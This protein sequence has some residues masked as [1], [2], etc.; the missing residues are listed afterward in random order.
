MK[1]S[2]KPR[3]FFEVRKG[4]KREKHFFSTNRI[5]S[6]NSI[7]ASEETLPFS[8]EYF[9]ADNVLVLYINPAN[10]MS[11][12]QAK[13]I[14]DF[15]SADDRTPVIVEADDVSCASA[16][17]KVLNWYFNCYCKDNYSVY[18]AFKIFNQHIAANDHICRI[19]L[20]ELQNRHGNLKKMMKSIRL[21]RMKKRFLDTLAGTYAVKLYQQ[22]PALEKWFK[23][24][25]CITFSESVAKGDP[26]V[27]KLAQCKF[28]RA[29]CGITRFDGKILVTDI[30]SDGRMYDIFAKMLKLAIPETYSV[31]GDDHKKF[32][33][34]FEKYFIKHVWQNHR[35]FLKLM[36]NSPKDAAIYLL[37]DALF[38]SANIY[39]KVGISIG[40]KK[41]DELYA[42]YLLS[43]SGKLDFEPE[44]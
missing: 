21:R 39:G 15:A 26:E 12:D 30:N 32:F 19:M 34:P 14:L 13:R 27:I 33:A 35:S 6:I 10:A 16:I 17:G 23:K 1:I 41:F 40:E 2:I 37:A 4:E 29:G 7:S 11:A 31:K 8:K 42:E 28:L 25:D 20:A 44:K 24:I 22:H 18:C 36:K 3:S 43:G 38:K 9:H 5:I